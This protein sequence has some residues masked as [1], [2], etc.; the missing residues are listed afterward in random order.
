MKV[1][2]VSKKDL[3]PIKE[4]YKFL[5]GDVYVV[6][7]D[8]EMWTWLGSKSYVDDKTVGA[9]MARILEQ[10][11][12]DLKIKTILESEEPTKF[13]EIVDFE[14]VEGD[15]PGFLKHFEKQIQ[16]D[17][18]LLQLREDDKGDVDIIDL[19]IG[20]QYFKSDDAFLLDAQMD[21]Y[22]WIGKDSQIKEKYEA[23]RISRML[24]VERKFAPLV[25]V[26]EE[27]NEPEGFRDMVFKLGIKDGVIELRT[28]VSKKEKEQKKWWQFWK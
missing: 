8:T 1:Y 15:T 12:Q 26:I 24:E 21:I 16:K 19:P 3:I 9:W 14:V 25:Y 17:L 10:K 23:G 2:H 5:N 28:T 11:N 6:E 7:T 22:I 13:T 18:R 4:P 27:E 20:Y